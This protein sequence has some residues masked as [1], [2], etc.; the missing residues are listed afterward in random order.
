MSGQRSKWL[1]RIQS[2]I[3]SL[4]RCREKKEVEDLRKTLQERMP[5]IP[6]L[7]KKAPVERNSTFYEERYK[8]IL[9]EDW[10][11]PF[12]DVLEAALV[13][14]TECVWYCIE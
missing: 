13:E 2:A 11:F 7:L 3:T 8:K 4:Q 10:G 14:F 12:H 5:A 1:K 9:K 6:N